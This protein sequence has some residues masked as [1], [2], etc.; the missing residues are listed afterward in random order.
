MIYALDLCDGVDTRGMDRDGWIRF[1]SD[2]PSF[3]LPPPWICWMMSPL[4]SKI[5]PVM[6]ISRWKKTSGRRGKWKVMFEGGRRR[7]MLWRLNR[8]SGDGGQKEETRARREVTG[9]RP[10][11]NRWEGGTTPRTRLSVLTSIR[12]GRRTLS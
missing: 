12:S 6:T 2:P 1:T 8:G 5:W 4:R 10:R 9:P 11:K 7:G 3:R